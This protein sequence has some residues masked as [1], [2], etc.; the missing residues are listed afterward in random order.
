MSYLWDTFET[1]RLRQ[2]DLETYLREVR[3]PWEFYIQVVN[4]IYTFW[5]PGALTPVTPS[6]LDFVFPFGRQEHAQDFHFSGLREESRLDPYQGNDMPSE[7]GRSGRDLRFC[8]NLRSVETSKSQTSL[9]WS[10][11]Q[12]AVY[13]T[14]DL[15]NG[16]LFWMLV[17]GNKDIK[18]RVTEASERPTHNR[19][20]SRT[21][22]FAASLATHLLLCNWS[23]ENWRWYINDL[24]DQFQALTRGALAFQVEKPPTSPSSPMSPDST[25]VSPQI[26]MGIFRKASWVSPNSF[27]PRTITLPQLVTTRSTTLTNNA[28]PQTHSQL[29]SPV[30]HNSPNDDTWM[31]S[32]MGRPYRATKRVT[33]NLSHLSQIITGSVRSWWLDDTNRR[34]T[35]PEEEKQV[36][37][38]SSPTKLTPPHLPPSFSDSDINKTTDIFTFSNLQQ[39][40]Y[41][42]EKAQEALL[43]LKMNTEVLEQLREHYQYVTNHTGFPQELSTDCKADLLHFDKGVLG[44]EKDLRMLQSRT[45]TLLHLLANRKTLLSGILQHRSSKASEFYA[46]ESRESAARMEK[47][48]VKM[49]DLA[50]ITK[51]ETVSMRV[52]T[53]VTLFFLPATFIATFMSTDILGFEDGEQDLQI[54]GLRLYLKIALPMTALTFFAWYIIYRLARREARP[55]DDPEA[56]GGVARMA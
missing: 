48:T 31:K 32:R 54:Q 23:G 24:E 8:Y 47:M 2:A 6:F 15:E 26:G 42:E 46:K 49:Q 55:N 4:G 12:C 38:L 53:T 56:S 13:H 27:S 34:S 7:L 25:V 29:Q 40:H 10:I 11:R 35:S 1:Y 43:V 18:D 9:P 30:G 33:S 44:V 52:I 39:I 3:G 28:Q 16:R 51:Q 20:K 17:K 21:E 37:L 19:I 22:T 14:F 5:I 45:E 50:M 36:P 41:I